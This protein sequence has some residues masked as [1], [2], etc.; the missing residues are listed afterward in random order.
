MDSN[1]NE[2]IVY[3]EQDLLK[4]YKFLKWLCSFAIIA[5]PSVVIFENYQHTGFSL[6]T[7]K[8]WPAIYEF[9]IPLI[10]VSWAISRTLFSNI[11]FKATYNHSKGLVT[12]YTTSK[13]D[14]IAFQIQ[15]I[16]HIWINYGSKVCLRNST[17]IKFMHNDSFYNFILKQNIPIIWGQ[18]PRKADHLKTFFKMDS[19]PIIGGWKY[20]KSKYF[21]KIKTQVNKS[22]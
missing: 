17:L 19:E 22:L 10:L 2:I 16:D 15:D 18:I 5:I 13:I 20:N 3:E 11:V 9:V 12:C 14:P 8:M 21:P 4:T 1:E 6:E 7:L